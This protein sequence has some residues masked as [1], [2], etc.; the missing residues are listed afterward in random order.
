MVD[1]DSDVCKVERRHFVQ[2]WANT[3]KPGGAFA[4][5]RD[6]DILG[7]GVVRPCIEG[8]MIGPL[9]ALNTAITQ[10]LL[11]TL[12]SLVPDKTIYID[13]LEENPSFI[14]LLSQDLQMEPVFESVRMYN[15]GDPGILRQKMFA[16]SSV[17]T[18]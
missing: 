14:Q 8:H 11:L 17:D 7:Y 6:R 9:Y 16:I 2:R 3:P 18:G 4:A 13:A 5:V 15:K 1:F 12:S 10:P